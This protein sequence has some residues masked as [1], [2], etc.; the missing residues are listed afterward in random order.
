MFNVINFFPKWQHV[1]FLTRTAALH[2][3]PIM[4]LII[5]SQSNLLLKQITGVLPF[6]VFSLPESKSYI[7]LIMSLFRGVSYWF[8]AVQSIWYEIMLQKWP[9]K[10]LSKMIFSIL[11]SFHTQMSGLSQDSDYV[12]LH[13]KLLSAF[14]SL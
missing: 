7:V 3:V 4:S 6:I 1:S 14:M 2:T 13:S 10:S 11:S 9:P 8:I 12:F 5:I